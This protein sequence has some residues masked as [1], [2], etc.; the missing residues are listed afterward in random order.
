MAVARAYKHGVTP[1][2]VAR[3]AIR[4]A[5]A[6]WTARGRLK[7]WEMNA[8]QRRVD[9]DRLATYRRNH[10]ESLGPEI[11]W[12]EC[13]A[14][15][16][17]IRNGLVTIEAVHEE[18]RKLRLSSLDPAVVA[19]VVAEVSARAFR[20][21]LYTPKR[22]GAK[23]ALTAAE[24]E[25]AGILKM[26]AINETKDERR[27]R[28]DRERKQEQRAAK[29]AQPRMT[30]KAMAEALGISRPTLDKWIKAGRADPETGQIMDFTQM[31]AGPYLYRDN[32][33]T[34]SVNTEVLA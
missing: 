18:A 25:A 23:L 20:Y 17:R 16:L 31:S 21:N 1:K 29:A 9:L 24:R 7:G 14:N 8:A 28:F 26:D 10:G 15:F 12:I 6:S 3:K 4:D 5:H 33:R 32:P 2:G 30:K 11:G 22:A 27:R 19:E 13:I 34:K